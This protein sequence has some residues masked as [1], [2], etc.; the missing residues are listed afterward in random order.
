[1]R[2]PLTRKQKAFFLIDVFAR[3]F[4]LA[5]LLR[6]IWKIF[7]SWWLGPLMDHHF[8]QLF[9][10]EIRQSI[11]FLFNLFGGKAIPPPQPEPKGSQ[12]ERVCVATESLVFQFSRWHREDYKVLVS[13]A[14]APK[15][16]YDLI[17]A[18]R[19]AGPTDR[20]IRALE[21]YL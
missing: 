10:A 8:D 13:P 2:R 9:V 5:W 12:I 14:F 18:L 6:L 21:L 3:F 20:E 16:S 19:V 11:P 15:N 7:F 4:C 17:D 1:L